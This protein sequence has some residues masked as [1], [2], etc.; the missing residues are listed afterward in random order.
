MNEFC[1]TQQII[2]CQEGK[3]RGGG[4]QLFCKLFCVFFNIL[5]RFALSKGQRPI[6]G[7]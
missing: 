2:V 6:Y 5:F 1:H 7:N 3:K 4:D